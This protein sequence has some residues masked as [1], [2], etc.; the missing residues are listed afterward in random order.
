[1]IVLFYIYVSPVFIDYSADSSFTYVATGTDL[2]LNSGQ[3]LK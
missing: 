2:R 3:C 1:M